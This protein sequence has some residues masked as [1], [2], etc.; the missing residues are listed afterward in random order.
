MGFDIRECED[1]ADGRIIGHRRCGP[2]T[3]ATQQ[4]RFATL[5]VG[6]TVGLISQMG[7]NSRQI[8]NGVCQVQSMPDRGAHRCLAW[9]R[10]R[11]LRPRRKADGQLVSQHARRTAEFWGP[12]ADLKRSNGSRSRNRPGSMAKQDRATTV[13][14]DFHLVEFVQVGLKSRGYV[15]GPLVVDP[16][17]DGLG[18]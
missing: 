7:A 4:D 11:Q 6:R 16:V 14:E 13:A 18:R 15:L 10:P 2:H 1:S 5:P 3:L 8:C 9:L 12:V 17:S